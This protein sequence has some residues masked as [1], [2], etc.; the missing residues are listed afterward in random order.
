MGGARSRTAKFSLRVAFSRG[1][2]GGSPTTK[3]KRGTGTIHSPPGPPRGGSALSLL[4][5][6][7]RSL[8]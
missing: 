8:T 6:E 2:E 4:V 5:L 7:R 1:D 3:D